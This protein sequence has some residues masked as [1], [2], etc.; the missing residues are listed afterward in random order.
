VA[1]GAQGP[2]GTRPWFRKNK[3]QRRRLESL[4]L[5]IRLSRMTG[6]GN[7]RLLVKTVRLAVEDEQ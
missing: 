1:E 3:A 6:V 2:R 5:A 7:E 4:P